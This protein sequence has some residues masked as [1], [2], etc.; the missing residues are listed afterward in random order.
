[1]SNPTCTAASLATT[2]PAFG[3]QGFNPKQYQA[4][5]LY[6][7]ALE[8]AA[9]GGT[10]YTATM[11]TDLIDDATTLAQKMDPN[12]RRIA[13]LQIYANNATAAGASVPETFNELNDATGCCFQSQQ[14][15]MGAIELL[16]LC[17]LGVHKAY[18]Q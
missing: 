14:V 6:L 18:P 15:D 4:A 10:D 1:M 13:M 12:Q 17:K 3:L 7:M 11:T 2:N 8:L 9:L 5:K 16:L